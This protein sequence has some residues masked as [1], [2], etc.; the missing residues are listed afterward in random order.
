M[1]IATSRSADRSAR[2]SG[3][4]TRTRA[5]PVENPV[6]RVLRENVV[7]GLANH[8]ILI[9]QGRRRS[10]RSTTAGPPSAE[11]GGA[12]DGVVLVFRDVTE[13]K[14]LEAASSSSG[15]RTWRR[16]TAARTSSWRCSPTS[17]AIRWPRSP[18]PSQLTHPDGRPRPRARLVHGG[19][20]PA[21]QAPDAADRR[22][23]AT[24]RGS[25]GARSSFARSGSTWHG[26]AGRHRVGTAADRGAA[27]HQL[28][29]SIAPGPWPTRGRPDPP[30]AD[31]DQ[32]ADQ[33][34]QVHRDRG[35]RSGCRPIATG[36]ASSSRYET[37]AWAS[38]PSSSRACSSCSPRG[39][40]RWP[41]RRGGWASG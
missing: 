38:R 19:H 31:R 1:A 41:A 34:R 28:N 35:S 15:W 29:V 13:R 27:R 22:P 2:S 5:K 14:R 9:A 26:R 11:T 32:P 3:S 7:V 6:A 25:R 24:S 17:C 36:G 23:A 12:I 21:G 37:R 39:T 16:P 8:T 4:S 30:R 40:A 18:T 20:Q 33:R 10:G